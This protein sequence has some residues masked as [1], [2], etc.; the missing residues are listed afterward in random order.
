M[1]AGCMNQAAR[2]IEKYDKVLFGT[3]PEEQVEGAH[4]K[5]RELLVSQEAITFNNE[6]SGSSPEALARR[7]IF[8]KKLIEAIPP[9]IPISL[10]NKSLDGAYLRTALHF[11]G[12][13]EL[14]FSRY[15]TDIRREANPAAVVGLCNAMH[16]SFSQCALA[17]KEL[18]S[19][20]V[21]IRE[22]TAQYQTSLGMGFG[23]PNDSV[24]RKASRKAYGRGQTYSRSASQVGRGLSRQQHRLLDAA[25]GAT[26]IGRDGLS[27]QAARL[28]RGACRSFLAGTCWRGDSCKFSHSSA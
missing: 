21:F 1:I 24:V 22:M 28:A 10:R 4:K 9:I 25:S 5:I 17:N 6:A 8:V 13:A 27:R 23:F 3:A 26:P 18:K 2:I 11:L 14:M 15:E 12:A 16:T 19:K 20:E 7:D